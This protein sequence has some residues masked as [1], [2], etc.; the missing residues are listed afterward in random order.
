MQRKRLNL[1]L[2][3][4]NIRVKFQTEI[5]FYQ[6]LRFWN[7]LSLVFRRF[8]TMSMWMELLI[9]TLRTLKNQTILKTWWQHFW[10][11]LLKTKKFQKPHMW[12]GKKKTSAWR[13]SLK[14]NLILLQV[15]PEQDFFWKMVKCLGSCLIFNCA[16]LKG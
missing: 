13:L 9:S 6:S 11:R 8:A 14:L 2:S 15:V 3:C 4:Q 12:N 7:N 16:Y 10:G 1:I 5:T